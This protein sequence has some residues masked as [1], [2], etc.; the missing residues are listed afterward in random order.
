IGSVANGESVVINV[1]ENDT[2]ADGT[3]D[4]TSIEIVDQ[5][6]HGTVQI[7][8]DGTVT[9]THD[10]SAS[11]TDSFTYTIRDNLGLISNVATVNITIS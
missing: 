1:A 7:N 9:Y 11:D 10:G 5:P 2:D 8:D 4:L 6:S 3:I